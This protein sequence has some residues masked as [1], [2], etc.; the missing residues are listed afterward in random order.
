MEDDDFISDGESANGENDDD[1]DIN[2][3]DNSASLDIGKVITF[4]DFIVARLWIAGLSCGCSSRIVG[5]HI[6]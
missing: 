2:S 6:F 5:A 1:F 3:E 4:P